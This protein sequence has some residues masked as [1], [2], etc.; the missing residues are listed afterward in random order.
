MKNKHINI[1]FSVIL[2]ITIGV[3]SFAVIHH[4]KNNSSLAVNNISGETT[5]SRQDGF[6]SENGSL[7]YYKDGKKSNYNGFVDAEINGEKVKY[8]LVNGKVDVSY[9]ALI[10]KENNLWW[11]VKNGKVSEVTDET[12]LLKLNETFAVSSSKD[13]F[14][15]YGGY[16]FSTETAEIIENAIK[17]V[18]KKGYKVGLCFYDLNSL[19][20]FSY[21]A[22]EKIY[23]ASAIKGPY[24]ASLINHDNSLLQKEK[25][26]INAILKNSSNVDYESLRSQY[27]DECV[28]NWS[29]DSEN[30][31][32]TDRDYQYITPHQL[33]ELW[34]SNFIFFENGDVGAEAGKLFENPVHS[35]IKSV[36]GDKYITR[37]KAGWVEKNNIEVTNDAGIVYANNKAYLITIMTT[38]PRDFSV[39]ETLATA[40]E[41]TIE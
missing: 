35:P 31:I 27:G 13:K 1:I 38:A 22:D 23:S 15:F 3:V 8:Y 33:S 26:R 16:T 29:P 9:N 5:T 40:I 6:Y 14:S 30:F 24:V 25:G 21:N 12:A 36:F 41:K 2:V 18:E 34:L 10:R 11:Y 20:G 39:V 32:K 19:E 4:H 7:F 28:V 37:T 17:T